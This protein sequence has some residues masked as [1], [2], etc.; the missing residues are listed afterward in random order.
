MKLP[1]TIEI[2]PSE[3]SRYQQLAKAKGQSLEEAVLQAVDAGMSKCGM[4]IASVQLS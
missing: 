1:I 4:E 2:E 3:V